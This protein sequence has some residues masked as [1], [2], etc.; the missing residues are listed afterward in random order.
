MN[1]AMN[2]SAEPTRPGLT[3]ANRRPRRW[4]WL[5]LR[6]GAA[7]LG[8]G[9]T[10]G[11]MLALIVYTALAHDL[12]RLDAFD[13]MAA[14][15]VTRFE[16]ADGSLVGER[17]TERRLALSWEELPRPLILAFLAAED[18]RFFEHS[19]LDFRGILRAMVTN[20][21]SGGVKEGASTITQ[22]LA[23]ILV[24]SERAW[25][26]KVK[27][28]ILA[29]RMEDL[30]SKEQILTW[31]INVVYF[32][33][34]SYGVQ[35]A[36]Q[37]YFRKNVW[38]LSLAEMAILAGCPQSPSRVNP[39]LD[40]A[41]AK[42][43]AVHILD[44]MRDL[45]W[46]SAAEVEEAK[47]F[48]YV[49]Y[50]LRDLWGD[51]T[52]DYTEAVRRLGATWNEGATTFL[53]RGLT[54]G[55]AVDPAAQREGYAALDAALVD[56]Q[57]KQGWP[58]PLAHL[59]DSE[60]AD[61]LAKNE[62]WVK[63][64]VD[65]EDPSRPR[66]GAR[67]LGLVTAVSEKEATLSL[68][69]GTRGTMSVA[70]TS[71]AVPWTV[72]PR[73]A[74][75]KV[76]R[77]GKVSFGGKATDLARVVAVGDVVLVR[78]VTPP[79]PKPAKKPA[80]AEKPDKK[81][82]KKAG[83][84]A[85][86]APAEEVAAAPAGAVPLVLE[87]E[88]IP[89]MEGVLVS[90]PIGGR[91]LDAMVTGWDFDRNEIDRTLSSRPSGST[92]KPIAYGLAY[93]LG[94]PP[95]ALI[96]AGDFSH[97]GYRVPGKD[98]LELLA[99]N[100]LVE[101]NNAVSVRV[102][103]HAL[104]RIQSG[105]WQRWAERLGLPGCRVRTGQPEG[106]TPECPLKAQKVGDDYDYLAEV[107]GASQRPRDVL[108]AFAT[109]GN[110]GRRP[111]LGLVR[112]VV[113]QSGA[114]LTRNLAPSDPWASSTDAFFA[115]AE[116]VRAPT[117]PAISPT[118]AY[119]VAKNLAAA[120]K[121][122]TGQRARTVGRE[123]AGKTGTLPY[124]VW[125]SG[126]TATRATVAWLGADDNERTLGP[127]ERDNKVYGAHA[128]GMWA[129]FMRALDAPSGS[130]AALAKRPG[131]AEVVPPDVVVVEIDPTTGLLARENGQ[132]IP[133][134]VGTEPKEMAPEPVVDDTQF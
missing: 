52:P 32:G 9:V 115:L 100:G 134:R 91:G 110:E 116:R 70:S 8:L 112:K 13:K 107:F 128:A 10:A 96:S 84:K 40:L 46:A 42:R 60:H 16:A 89:M 18:A 117:A 34:R 1:E 98:G 6:L 5:L 14:V 37:N 22:Q 19:G 45:G 97:K 81:P 62:R 41:G 119:L 102:F 63:R 44:N 49:V 30:Y 21:F 33:H 113:D 118:T 11:A 92:M 36:A 29:R 47:K 28:A 25:S 108:S 71:W 88:P 4:P 23:K 85:T 59:D 121:S 94:L 35:A 90:T 77:T 38:E 56:L 67:L 50:P 55:M 79:P 106:A 7:G 20:V 12:P 80:K 105:D 86:E 53:E 3:V 93:D 69:T 122:G 57:K 87:L 15:G 76:V 73:D 124:D 104:D 48:E 126:F 114:V 82:G 95:S 129:D 66:T 51:E 125:F 2:P 123:A 78:V 68:A 99:W 61:F 43:R 120:V 75:D 101:S 103:V 31:Y 131:V 39:A 17:F 54:L 64:A 130:K 72:F 127:S 133:H 132:A 65:G 83:P 24:G 74:K 109:Y 58:G 27:E 26:R 111:E